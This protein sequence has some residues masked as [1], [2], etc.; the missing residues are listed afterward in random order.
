[1]S[2]IGSKS[3]ETRPELSIVIPLYNEALR[4]PEK[5]PKYLEFLEGSVSDYEIVL[6][7]DGSTDGTADLVTR[8]AA[9]SSKIVAAGDS[10]NRGRGYR[11]KEGALLAK[12]EY[13]LETD[14]DLPVPTSF[15]T[16]F[17][18]FLKGHPDV[19]IVIGSR[20]MTASKFLKRQSLLR[21]LAA[22]VFHGLYRT[23]FRIKVRDVM[24]GFKMFRHDAARKIFARVYDERYL[25][26]AEIVHA[27]D[28]MKVPYVEMPI[29]WEDNRNSRVKIMS[30][31]F[32]TLWGMARM[33]LRNLKGMYN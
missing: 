27:A 19:D 20:N 4:L 21:T 10:T 31:T 11:M 9:E 6:V 16:S 22:A 7:N 3:T 28:R 12:G 17:M 30:A 29:E 32:A 25:A 5:L 23:L 15:V 8:L 24:C 14:A 1:M 26:A 33:F 18:S 13:I 2:L